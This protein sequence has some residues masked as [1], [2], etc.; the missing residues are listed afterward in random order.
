M[1]LTEV[2]VKNYKSKSILKESWQDLTESQQVYVGRWETNVWPLLENYQ[3][4]LEQDLDTRQ[5]QKI[6]TSAEQVSS[7][8]GKNKTALGKTGEKIG[9]TAGKI[10][11]EIEKL[12][13]AAQKTA[14]V[15]NFDNKFNNLKTKLSAKLKTNPKGQNILNALDKWKDYATEN[16]VKSTFAI[17]AMTT[18]LAFASGGASSGAAIGLLMRT[19]NNTIKGDDLSSAVAKSGSMT[20]LGAVAGAIG[21]M[22]DNGSVDIEKN[23]INEPSEVSA[24]VST[25]NTDVDPE[26]VI[27]N[28]EE[29]ERAFA[30]KIYD[31]ATKSNFSNN[32][33]EQIL[34]KMVNDVK[35]DGTKLSFNGTFVQGFYLTPNELQEYQSIVSNNGGGLEGATSDEAQNYVRGVYDIDPIEAPASEPEPEAS[36]SNQTNSQNNLPSYMQ[37]LSDTEALNLFKGYSNRLDDALADGNNRSAQSLSRLMAKMHSGYPELSDQ[38]NDIEAETNSTDDIQPETSNIVLS[39]DSNGRDIRDAIRSISDAGFSYDSYQ[40]FGGV[41]IITVKLDDFVMQDIDPDS[42]DWVQNNEEGRRLAR[43]A[44]NKFTSSIDGD[45]GEFS[46]FVNDSTGKSIDAFNGQYIEESLEEQLWDKLELYEFSIVAAANKAADAI[47]ATVAKTAQGVGKELANTI[48][49]KKL[50]RLWKKSGSPTDLDSIINILQSAG[51]DDKTIGTVGKQARIS[52][53]RQTNIDDLAKEIINSG[54]A[55]LVK[56][57]L[58]PKAPQDRKPVNKGQA[59]AGIS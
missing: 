45:I 41:K 19:A 38:F 16:P 25:D 18:L 2:S 26:T 23:D 51:L 3:K 40:G 31:E 5:I 15:Q 7:A 34:D 32:Y 12:A 28:P 50:N 11:Q 27:D 37:N 33:K 10:K 17:A 1:K 43:Q 44:L 46:F 59:P 58:N 48:T 36:D 47:G 22:W 29:F 42:D 39:A 56:K 13:T 6:F 53:D 30:E 20:A 9:A 24:E 52:L 57:K 55:D 8:I 35:V 4:L 54:L 49:T 14:P 21:D